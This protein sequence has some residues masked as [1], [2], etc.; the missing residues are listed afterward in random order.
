L[1]P[2]RRRRREMHATEPITEVPVEEDIYPP[3]A[4]EAPIPD[5]QSPPT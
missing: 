3:G 2:S 5:Q 4:L 1:I